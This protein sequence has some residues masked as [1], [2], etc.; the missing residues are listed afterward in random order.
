MIHHVSIPARDPRHVAEV[1]AELMGGQCHPFGPL[2]GAF[3]ATSGDTYGTMIEVYPRRS[4]LSGSALL[5][6]RPTRPSPPTCR[7]MN[8][9]SF[10]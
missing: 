9:A 8:C 5:L 1:L 3:M 7:Q 2:E 10:W 6:W 4:K